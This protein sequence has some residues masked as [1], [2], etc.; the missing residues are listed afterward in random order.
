MT[1]T[2]VLPNSSDHRRLQEMRVGKSNSV[3]LAGEIS[4]ELVSY[5]LNDVTVTW[6]CFVKLKTRYDSYQ[7]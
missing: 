4:E 3:D 5:C 6:E 2:S 7:L 1:P